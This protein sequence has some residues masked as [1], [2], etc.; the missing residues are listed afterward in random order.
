MTQV[1]L[2]FEILASYHRLSYVPLGTSA[3]TSVRLILVILASFQNFRRVSMGYCSWPAFRSHFSDLGQFAQE[4]APDFHA[5]L[6]H[7]YFGDF[8][9]FSATFSRLLWDIAIDRAWFNFQFCASQ[10][11]QLFYDFHGIWTW[12]YFVDIGQF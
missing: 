9:L 5:T 8:V 4:R 6:G 12:T 7:I 3:L 11:P 1:G 10:F 2:I